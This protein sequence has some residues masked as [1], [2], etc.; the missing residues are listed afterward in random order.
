MNMSGKLKLC[1]RQRIAVAGKRVVG[2]SVRVA[3]LSPQGSL[4][5]QEE[6]LGGKRAMGC[7][8]F[9]PTRG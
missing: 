7:G 2:F 4:R 5:L 1:G 6:G 8:L 3:E 9:R